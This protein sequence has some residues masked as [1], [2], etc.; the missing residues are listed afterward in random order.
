MLLLFKRKLFYTVVV[1][2]DV[3]QNKLNTSKLQNFMAYPTFEAAAKAWSRA[4]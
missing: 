1:N 3:S 4:F 2:W